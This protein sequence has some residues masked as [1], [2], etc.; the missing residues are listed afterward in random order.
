MHMLGGSCIRYGL[1]DMILVTCE[2][3]EG[4][5]ACL[6]RT[7]PDEQVFMRGWLCSDLHGG[8][9]AQDGC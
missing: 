3:L 6:C 9:G 8:F 4:V 5:F 2:P 7:L 1:L